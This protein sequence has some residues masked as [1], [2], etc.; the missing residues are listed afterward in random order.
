MCRQSI[1]LLK[2]VVWHFCSYYVCHVT[3][4]KNYLQIQSVTVNV[5]ILIIA[6]SVAIHIPVR[7]A[8]ITI[9]TCPFCSQVSDIGVSTNISYIHGLPS[10]E[11]VA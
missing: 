10:R 3:L 5:F 2:V 8:I 9:C 6:A 4:L 11:K 1:N 7:M